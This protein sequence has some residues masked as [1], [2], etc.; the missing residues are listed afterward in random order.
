MIF[1]PVSELFV[2]F[3]LST[4]FWHLLMVSRDADH[5]LKQTTI[6]ITV[7]MIW[8]LLAFGI[9][10]YRIDSFVLGPDFPARPLLYLFLASVVAYKA[11]HWILGHGVS[12]HLLI[13]LQLIRP[14]GMV[15]VLEHTQG[16]LPGIFAY[17]AGLG[18]L[19]TGILAAIVLYRFWGTKIPP[20][21]VLLVAGVGLLDFVSA[22][23]FGFTSSETPVQLFSFENPNQVTEY[24]LGLIPLFLVPYAVIAHILSLTQLN[25]DR[26]TETNA[27]QAR[28]DARS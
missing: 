13:G 4:P 3:F 7:A 21:W 11:R 25:R 19:L 14:I 27:E 2:L 6:L 18:D 17:P 12:Q 24:P 28:L 10:K 20:F 26:Q 15:F 8:C 23:F 22:F 1:S 9:V 5:S 16:N